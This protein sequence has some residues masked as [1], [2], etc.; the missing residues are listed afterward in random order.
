MPDVFDE[1]S[2]ET[3]TVKGD[4][5]DELVSGGDVFDQLAKE[6]QTQSGVDMLRRVPAGIAK[7]SA[8]AAVGVSRI[9]EVLPVSGVTEA[10]KLIP[11]G[12]EL[13]QKGRE[14]F[15]GLGESAAGAYGVDERQ[16]ATIP[17]KLISGVSSLVPAIA[18]GPAAP[19]AMAGMMGEG[20][21]QEAE[22]KGAT[23]KQKNIAFA[24]GATVGAL[25]EF[26]LG[27]PAL[28]RAA[29]AAKIPEATFK[30]ISKEAA[31]QAVKSAG[32]E[33][34]QE[35]LEQIGQNLIASKIAAYDPERGAFAN[36]PESVALG[37]AIG[38]PVGAAVQTA[39]SLDAIS[40]QSR[41]TAAQVNETI[42]DVAA[43]EPPPLVPE[44][45][46]PAVVEQVSEPAT[47]A[48]TPTLPASEGVTF[49]ELPPDVVEVPEGALNVSK[50]KIGTGTGTVVEYP[51]R[52]ELKDLVSLRQGEGSGTAI[53]D[54]LKAKGKPI[55]LVAGRRATDTPIEQLTRFYEKRGFRKVEG[56]PGK[57][58]W[59]PAQTAE[60]D[61]RAI[62]EGYEDLQKLGKTDPTIEELQEASG[63]PA[64]ALQPW[65]DQKAAAG[66]AR[67][68]GGRVRL[69]PGAT[70]NLDALE[71]EVF[72]TKDGR[73]YRVGVEE[74]TSRSGKE[75][76][77]AVSV[78]AVDD[79]GNV[80]GSVTAKI[81]SE[82]EAQTHLANVSPE[83]RR[84][85]VYTALLNRLEAKG[86]RITPD[87][88]QSDDAKAFWSNRRATQPDTTAIGQTAPTESRRSTATPATEVSPEG[89][90][91]AD[92]EK[93]S[94]AQLK[95]RIDLLLSRHQ[96][97]DN[98]TK[99][100]I[101]R[102]VQELDRQYAKATGESM[103]P[104]AASAEEFIAMRT[105]GLKKAVVEDER[106][107]SGLA[108]LPPAERQIEEAR[109]Q[110]AEDRVDQNATLAPSLVKRIVDDG[111]KA[112]DPDDAAVLLVERT[113]LM[114][115]R[116]QW[117]ERVANGEDVEIS[118]IRLNEI[119]VALDRL[120]QAQRLAGSTWGRV[121]H[122]YQRMMR[123]DYSLEAME[124]RWRGAKQDT[125]SEKERA[126]V[127]ELAETVKRT[128]EGLAQIESTR[129]QEAAEAQADE[130]IKQLKKDVSGTEGHDP[131]VASIAERIYQRLKKAAD[132][133]HVSLRRRLGNLYANPF[134]I[135]IAKDVAIIA[136]EWIAR[137]IRSFS[138]FR[139]GMI[140]EYGEKVDPYLE[141]AWKEA[142]TM[143]DKAVEKTAVPKEKKAKVKGAVKKL[144][145]GQ[146]REKA[147]A[148]MANKYETNQKIEE[149]RP[150][151]RKIA[152][153]FVRDGITEREPL[154]DAVHAMVTEVAPDVTR[155]QTMDMISGYG[156]FA[157]LDM[158]TA[159]VQL[160]DIKGQL[161]QIAKLEDLQKTP[162]S[163]K[164]TGIERRKPS[165]AERHLIAKV[166]ELMRE[167]G[168]GTMESLKTRL[169]NRTVDLQAKMA[170]GDFSKKPVRKID[171]SKDPEAVKLKAENIRAKKEFERRKLVFE[172]ENRTRL[173]Q[174]KA[175]ASEV[176]TLPR[177]V[178]SSMDVSAVLRQ[179]GVLGAGN[180]KLAARAIKTMFESLAS[181][182]G[183]EKGQAEIELR[184]NS[185]NG[186][187]DIAK[188]FLAEVG[189]VKL[190]TKEEAFISEL[191][192]KIPGV[193]ASNRAYV[194]YLNRLRADA[195]D[196]LVDSLHGG[197]LLRK[198]G[199][200]TPAELKAIANYV[201]I[202]T[203]RG[204]LGSYAQA[205]QTLAQLLFSPRLLA[206]RFQLI[207]G[208]PLWGG[209]GRTRMLIAKEYAKSLAALGVMLGLG[210]LAGASME[211]DPRSSD[212]GK[213]RFGNT[214]VD[215]MAGLSQVT[216]LAAR[217]FSGTKKTLRG[218]IVPIRDSYRLDADR[219][220][221]FGD[222]DASDV[223]KNFLRS[224]LAPI[225]ASLTDVLSGEN[226][227][228]NR[229]VPMEMTEKFP[230]IRGAV[231]ELFVPLSFGDI[232]KVMKE[233]GVPAG[234]A[235]T[236]LSLFGAGV[237]VYGD[238]NKN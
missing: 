99:R 184:E 56:S 2:A 156:D 27:V 41:A 215:L 213:M 33:G 61:V 8:D 91:T 146:V 232:F 120:D 206:S 119:E 17:S 94:A 87:A 46:P 229:V 63:I 187:Y 110:A 68:E 210:A 164:K 89:P 238:R 12:R 135:G 163:V 173:E 145:P 105:T 194:G 204:D 133:A 30:A 157:P 123:S 58:R 151:V 152:L 134:D 13:I 236:L 130:A 7:A 196:S 60:V 74:T 154:V 170:A 93:L 226:V 165:H 231:P 212:F 84:Q 19:L 114:N 193:R 37:A 167:N 214:R 65:L 216:V 136:A 127:K 230:F 217:L 112:I 234:S 69:D 142:N 31:V 42:A 205:A 64:E 77:P 47:V 49:T 190:S 29:K 208:Q 50:A 22:A 148:S 143:I 189:D 115:E 3:Q 16:D 14:Y 111:D 177:A 34:A 72:Q 169:R 6:P 166:N 211:W 32:R 150:Y 80:I 48:P 159:K 70:I 179:G 1:L 235:L 9:A 131:L 5:F 224:K 209:T 86:Y 10:A 11:G 106:I 103:G 75:S 191:A 138:K 175:A 220:R 40:A 96:G 181:E 117:E 98:E 81:T 116:Q 76:V 107:R 195:F 59:D 39:V 182:K 101:W 21:R 20:L 126:E 100:K 25:S 104:G 4:I 199:T 137:G 174:A 51:D 149:L 140:E 227:V 161:Q 79:S 221:G 129:D 124:S 192:D 90:Q 23:E 15:E 178:K 118:K 24:G 125:L 185:K 200:A 53:I 109:V 198:K 139:S 203:G 168:V 113:R 233:N 180:P 202:S 147:A 73:G 222:D 186:Y 35:G 45:A 218:D 153:S 95:E 228:G 83:W 57:F 52:I 122:L 38:A 183:F 128:D 237:Q 223:M 82:G 28:L 26:L 44:A 88:A 176:L 172:R 85:G 97:A 155:R 36:V 158:E 92:T 108:A 62:R 201:N 121:G 18:S 141:N 132:E 160:R 225:P 171:I 55:E 78:F 71:P 43:S 207:A 54:A 188:L 162:P 219:K 144:D 102:E 197:G 66:T 67:V